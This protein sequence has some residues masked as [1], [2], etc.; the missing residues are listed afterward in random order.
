MFL[1]NTYGMYRKGKMNFDG[2]DRLGLL[3]TFTNCLYEEKLKIYVRGW[4]LNVSII[5]DN[6]VT[7]IIS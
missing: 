7:F 1:I 4:E 2:S 6:G 5:V 3:C